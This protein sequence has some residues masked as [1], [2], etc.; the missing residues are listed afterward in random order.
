[1]HMLVC[2]MSPTSPTGSLSRI[3]TAGQSRLQPD[4]LLGDEPSW[5]SADPVTGRIWV[6]LHR[7][8][9]V[10]VVMHNSI[11]RKIYTGPG[12]FAV[13]VDAA[14]RLVYVGNREF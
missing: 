14:R 2:S 6:T 12:T 10:A 3:E 13:A 7:G 8:S 11:W 9:G 5:V 4:V 1:M